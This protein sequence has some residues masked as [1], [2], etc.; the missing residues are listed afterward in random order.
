MSSAPSSQIIPCSQV[1]QLRE[2][3]GVL[4]QEAEALLDVSRRLD[5][6]FCAA[7][8][9]IR[10]CRAS[11]IVTGIG[12]AGLIAQKIAA[13][14]SSTGTRAHF[15]HAAEAVHGDLGCL[16]PGDV[17]LVLSNSGETEE[18]C[19]WLP[20][21]R[22][23][24]L[25]VIAITAAET[26]TLGR[27]ADITLCLGRLREAGPDGLAPSTSTTAMLG[28]GDALA[29]VVSRVKGFTPQQFAVFHPGGNLGR[30]LTSV[31]DVMR[32]GDELRTAPG[33]ATIR[34]IIVGLRR[35]GRRTGAVILV[36]S[37]AKLSGIFTDSDL[38]RLLEQRRDG[39][40]DR[41]IHEVMT[42]S[43]LTIRPEQS[44]EDAV[45][46][47]SSRKIS[48]LPVVDREG[49]PVGLLDITDVI[50][51][52]PAEASPGPA[53]GLHRASHASHAG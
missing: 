33:T 34:E 4:R 29:L 17:L 31:R 44:L 46:L 14:F 20:A 53:P 41:P 9:T 36:D 2:A 24:G 18:V 48:E 23:M 52:L 21:I 19:R 47:F 3:R 30:R 35:A 43:P 15:L 28:L 12:K 38:V 22:R 8:Q 25:P 7:V 26:S 27:Q 1:E 49:T 37:E 6:A 45:T 39:Q 13:T 50:S 16:G 51:C 11:V 5:A 10:D 42:R 40:L 32:R